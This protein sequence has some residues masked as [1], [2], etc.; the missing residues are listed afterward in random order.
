MNFF[1]VAF[2]FCL[3]KNRAVKT[4]MAGLLVKTNKFPTGALQAEKIILLEGIFIFM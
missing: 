4:S 3:F 2:F 1:V